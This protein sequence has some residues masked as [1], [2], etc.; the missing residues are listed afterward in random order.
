MLEYFIRRLLL[1]IPT[2]F[3]CTI[4]VF[5][6][7]TLAPGGP[8]EQ[9]IRALRGIGA[10]EASGA[11]STGGSVIPESA[12]LELKRY[13]GF[14]KPIY[15]QYLTWLGVYPRETES[16]IV[17]P[18]T[19]RS[20]GNNKTIIVKKEGGTYIIYDG[21][22]QSQKSTD[23][24]IIEPQ[25]SETGEERVR[26][27]Q[28]G[29]SGILTFDFGKSYDYREPV[30]NLISA[31]IPVSFQFGFLGFVI[32]YTVCI[33]LGIQ[34]ALRHN[35][36]FDFATSTL[37][38]VGYSIPGWALGAMLLVLLG[39]G[40]FFDVFP[41]GGMYSQDYSSLSLGEKIVDRMYHF[42]LPTLAYTIPSFAGLTMLMKN[43]LL[44]NLSQDYI[45]TAFAKG[46]R[47]QRVIWVHA[48]RN[49]I[50]P[51]TAN[52]GY[53]IGIFLTSNYLIET[54]FNIDGIGKLSFSAIGSRDYPI[55]FSFTVISVIITLIG[56]II[57]DLALA[58]VDPRIRFK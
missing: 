34:K 24:W 1:T 3:G 38:I 12:L 56:S 9:Q 6:I 8:L 47:E 11:S 18:E 44:D 23:D 19:K 36:A 40:S 32:S 5:F 29:F 27:Y 53:I 14:D 55:V 30:I 4:V 16:F 42:V 58:L 45:R 46:L 33:Y 15:I 51:I 37:V 13:Y 20:V 39:G 21:E 43:S 26:V 17:E 10:G 52:I 54:V 31:R 49:S 25:K 2:F 35:S 48:M 22:N 57:S 41:L 50:I 7:V 28:T